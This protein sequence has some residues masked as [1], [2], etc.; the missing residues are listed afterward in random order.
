M[1]DPL[2]INNFQERRYKV[3]VT[4]NYAFAL[5]FCCLILSDFATHARIRLA[6][7]SQS[8]VYAESKQANGLAEKIESRSRATDLM[9][10][11]LAQ[12]MLRNLPAPKAAA[13]LRP[14]VQEAIER[15]GDMK[16]PTDGELKLPIDEEAHWLLILQNGKLLT[17]L[18]SQRQLSKETTDLSPLLFFEGQTQCGPLLVNP[19]QKLRLSTR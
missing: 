3:Q 17:I 2:R 19:R 16:I 18:K 13:P 4:V 1:N 14:E 9:V 15:G 11:T 8:L 6:E 10:V 7:V 5:A 12:H